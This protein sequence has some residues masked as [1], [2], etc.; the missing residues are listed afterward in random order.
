M[1]PPVRITT[2]EFCK[3]IRLSK[4]T[5][6]RLS[7][8]DANFPKEIYILNQKLFFQDEV[9][10]YIASLEHSEPTRNNLKVE[11]A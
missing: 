1:N 5:L 2:N 11:V 7:K 9:T 6:W 8:R 10:A 3:Q 4:T